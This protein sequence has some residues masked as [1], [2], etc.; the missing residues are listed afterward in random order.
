MGDNVISHVSAIQI[1]SPGTCMNIKSYRTPKER[2]KNPK[3][4]G[5][6]CGKHYKKPCKWTPMSPDTI[7]KR[8]QR[9]HLR[10][11]QKV[12]AVI[13]KD[14]YASKIQKWYRLWRSL[15]MIRRRGLAYYDR[16][17]TT[18]D[19]DFFST[20][21]M[22]D[23]SGIMFFSYKDTD[24]HYYGFDI[25]SIHTVIYRAR[26]SG[27]TPQN[28]FT[29]SPITQPIITKVMKLTKFLTTHNYTIEWAPLTPPTPEQQ[30]RMKVVDLF[31]KIDEL[32]YYS[33]PDWFIGLSI[34]GQ[35]KLYAELHGI[36]TH[37]AGLSIAQ[38]SL[39][40]PNYAQRLFR[41]PP[42]ALGDQTIESMQKI[43]MNVM[44]TMI[45]SAEDRN[46]RI[47]GAMYV[48]SGL[49]LVNDQARA[50]YPWL[51]E[52]VQGHVEAPVALGGPLLN[53]RVYNL[54][55]IFGIGW[56]NDILTLTPDYANMPPLQLPP[57]SPQAGPNN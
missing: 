9:R 14:A 15:H 50:A 36:W 41:H 10:K 45:I 32:N 21:S 46:D 42:W 7:A 6:F 22:K 13:T 25:R 56:L 27:E 49:T 5:D 1:S 34:N 35:R 4:H 29:R 3:T 16:S 19:S 23:I 12:E 43:N 57:P 48:V 20:D 33:S 28:P 44:R 38:K 51:Y 54:G 18:N 31:H 39:I 53:G 37:R 17:I 8:V 26:V 11:Q 2:C 47:V 55:N 30:W 40:V 52:S 24:G